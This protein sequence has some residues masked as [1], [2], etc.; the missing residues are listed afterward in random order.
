MPVLSLGE[1]PMADVLLTLEQLD[2]VEE[3]YPLEVAFCPECYL[4]QLTSVAPPEK[5]YGEDYPY[6]TSALPGLVEHYRR[7]ALDL[8]ER[9][10]LGP[11]SLVIEGG[12]NDGYMLEVFA[13]EG[14]QVLGVDPAPQP[15][16]IANEKGLPTICD[17]F[18]AAIGEKLRGEGKRA[19]LLVANNLLNLVP[20]PKDFVKAVDLLLKDDGLAV[21][22]VPNAVAMIDAGAFD[23]IFHQNRSYWSLSA[24][25]KL[26]ADGGLRVT[27]AVSVPTFGGSYRTFVERDGTPSQGRDAALEEE[28]RRNVTSASFYEAFAARSRRNRI[29]LVKLLQE[30]KGKG[31]TIAAYGAAGG[32]ATTLM[33]FADIDGSLID[34]AVD[35]NSFKHG[36]YT[37][38]SHILI[39]PT[40]RLLED[41]PG[42]V[43]LLAWNYVDEILAGQAEYRR[44]GGKF[45]IPIP[46][47]RIV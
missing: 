11:S 40:D 25:V 19:D 44:R 8:V 17:F 18:S 7:S 31:E 47:L 42:Y 26:F 13:K 4:L 27:D 12:S 38:G 23:T 6:F 16:R 24:L 39:C 1:T 30:L 35:G 2:Q 43:L 21:I 36:K 15:A 34:F 20:D 14:V 33:S 22:E 5:I 28:R 3:T 46:E 37:P 10:G 41:M 32:M 45:I 29:E 9:R